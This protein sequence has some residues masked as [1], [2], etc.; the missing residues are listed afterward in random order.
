[1]L[2]K[3]LTFIR[4]WFEAARRSSTQSDLDNW[5][6]SKNPTT[7]AELDFWLREY[8]ERRRQYTRF[9]SSGHYDKARWIMNQ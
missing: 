6:R 5:I 2:R 9:M 7:P 3:C 1:M 8:D 4:R